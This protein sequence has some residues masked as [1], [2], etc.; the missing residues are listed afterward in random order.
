MRRIAVIIMLLAVAACGPDYEPR[1]KEVTYH[2]KRGGIQY[3]YPCPDWS[4]DATRNYDNSVHSNF[5]CAANH[6]LAVQLE[7]PRDLYRGHGTPGPD[8]E[9]TARTVE[10]YRAG[11]LPRPLEPQQATS[12]R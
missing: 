3:N 4:H 5:G 11:D 8:A 1:S 12:S 9:I 6:N 10:Q 2:P 7:D